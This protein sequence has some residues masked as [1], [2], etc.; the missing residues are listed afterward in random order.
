MVCLSNSNVTHAE[1]LDETQKHWE[2][3]LVTTEG[4]FMKRFLV[5]LLVGGIH[6]SQALA[7]ARGVFFP[8][9]PAQAMIIIQGFSMEDGSLDQD[10]YK[11]Y[12]LLLAPENTLPSGD[13][14]KILE[15]SDKS[16]LL[17]CVERPSGT[18]QCQF[19]I[20]E[21][22]FT[23]IDK[24]AKSLNYVRRDSDADLWFTQ[25]QPTEEGKFL[26]VTTDGKFKLYVTPFSLEIGFRD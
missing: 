6:W 15:T 11:L 8:M 22:A 19:V 25:F 17:T 13:K 23:E 10:P 1:V 14:G 3:N 5:V 20:K 7:A 2:H 12:D 26:F 9:S 21:S 16:V 4:V 18:R 24:S